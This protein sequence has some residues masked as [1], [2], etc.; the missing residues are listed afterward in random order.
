M[1]DD[2]LIAL[3]SKLAYQE[4]HIQSLND[5]LIAMQKQIDRLE[6]TCQ[7]L[8]DKLGAMQN[9]MPNEI[10]GDEIPPHY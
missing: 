3:E 5:A 6:L 2:R 1:Q 9:P 7:G 4:D 10:R 8:K